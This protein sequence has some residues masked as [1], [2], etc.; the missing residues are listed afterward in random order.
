MPKEIAWGGIDPGKSGCACL[1]TNEKIWF[2]DFVSEQ[3]AA[4]IIDQ[5]NHD[6]RVRFLLEKVQVIR[7]KEFLG[8]FQILEHYGF[9]RGV[10]VA[11]NC[12]FIV[13]TP[14]QWQKVMPGKRK[15]TETTKD[16]SLNFARKFYPAAAGLLARKKDNN[17]ADALLMAH[18]IRQTEKGL[19][20]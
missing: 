8:G 6:Y 10:L 18:Y 20:K 4:E 19:F 2:H 14:L 11:F 17:R 3:K 15:R 1:L 9:W 12:N 7:K 5:W 16:R 13:K